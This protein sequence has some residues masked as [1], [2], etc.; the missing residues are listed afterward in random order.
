MKEWVEPPRATMREYNLVKQSLEDILESKAV[1]EKTQR[2]LDKVCSL[3]SPLRFCSY[4]IASK[5]ADVPPPSQVL[6][7]VESLKTDVEA[8]QARLNAKREIEQHPRPLYPEPLPAPAIPLDEQDFA[9]LEMCLGRCGTPLC[10]KHFKADS[11]TLLAHHVLQG[12]FVP[13]VSDLGYSRGH[14]S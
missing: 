5:R 14:F 8:E 6:L 11:Q 3:C 4:S 9:K 13:S 12:R 2:A 1:D 7:V 10:V